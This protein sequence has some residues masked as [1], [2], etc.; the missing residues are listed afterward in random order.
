MCI[1][2]VHIHVVGRCTVHKTSNLYA[3]LNTSNCTSFP[4][5]RLVLQWNI[6]N[7]KEVL[8]LLNA[9]SQLRFLRTYIFCTLDCSSSPR[10]LTYIHT[11]HT[12]TRARVW[13]NK[14]FKL[15]SITLYILKCRNIIIWSCTPCTS[16]VLFSAV[17]HFYTVNNNLCVPNEIQLLA[18]LIQ[19]YYFMKNRS[20]EKN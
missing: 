17:Q 20:R 4:F 18:V 16:F 5:T 9:E 6:W 8:V 14:F 11:T 1:L 13:V 19:N 2:L 3:Y 12:V 15:N 10:T 7:N